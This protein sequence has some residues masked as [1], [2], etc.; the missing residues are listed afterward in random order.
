MRRAEESG[1]D[2]EL[3]KEASETTVTVPSVSS[4]SSQQEFLQEATKVLKSMRLARLAGDGQGRCLV[5][6]GATTS[7]RRATSPE[8]VQGLP[9]RVV[10]LAVGET[11]FYV[12]DAGTLI[13]NGGPDGGWMPG[14][15]DFGAG[16]YGVA[17]EAWMAPD[18]HE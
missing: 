13:S 17:S 15:L 6:G 16:M 5:D 10:K 9:R 12:N 18:R 2:S 4:A 3:P 8:E 11:R 7:M 14:D 1:K